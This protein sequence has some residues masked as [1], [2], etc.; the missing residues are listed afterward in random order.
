MTKFSTGLSLTALAGGLVF[1]PAYLVNAE[2]RMFTSQSYTQSE[3]TCSQLLDKLMPIGGNEA[4]TFPRNTKWLVTV[5]ILPPFGHKEAFL[6]LRKLYSG[7][8]DGLIV[9][10]MGGSIYEQ[11]RALQSKR[12]GQ[13]VA[14][15]AQQVTV[16]RKEF[17]QKDLPQISSFVTEF[18]TITLSPVLPDELSNDSTRYELWVWSQ[19]GQHMSVT[20]VG[21]GLTSEKQPHPLLQWIEDYRKL[22][23]QH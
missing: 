19:Y 20:L 11:C 4:V 12:P 16:R 8:A 15:S 17:S 1:P 21:P 3:N 14:E 7:S 9:T 10:P 13:S 2:R 22:L 18:E 5:R 23:E 6:S